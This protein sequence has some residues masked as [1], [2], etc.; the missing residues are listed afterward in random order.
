MIPYY[1][2]SRRGHP[3]RMPFANVIRYENDDLTENGYWCGEWEC[4][5][6]ATQTMTN[7]WVAIVRQLREQNKRTG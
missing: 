5:A 4:Y 2:N 6:R 3:D 7:E 1:V